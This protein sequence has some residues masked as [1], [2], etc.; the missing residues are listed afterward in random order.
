MGLGY[1]GI[2]A[3]KKGFV[4]KTYIRPKLI[5]GMDNF[6]LN[7][8]QIKKLQSLDGAILKRLLDVSKYCYNTELFISLKMLPMTDLC[9]RLKLSLFVRLA[10]NELLYDLLNNTLRI[11]QAEEGR[12]SIIREVIDILGLM[13]TGDQN[14]YEIDEID[15][16]VYLAMIKIKE[17]ESLHK[18]EYENEILTNKVKEIMNKTDSYKTKLNEALVPRVLNKQH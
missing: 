10:K 11:I 9:K 15:E 13:R 6:E 4:Y 5:Y 3:S 14:E 8:A 2:E 7:S 16:L 18:G 17:I 12:K 1:E